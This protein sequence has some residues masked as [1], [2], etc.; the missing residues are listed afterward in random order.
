M[1]GAVLPVFLLVAAVTGDHVSG[2]LQYPGTVVRTQS[3][4]PIVRERKVTKKIPPVH[5]LS[6]S[7]F[8]KARS[9]RLTQISETSEVSLE[10][11]RNFLQNDAIFVPVVHL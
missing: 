6:L 1:F 4:I 11:S 8:S 7:L 5:T 2:I 10:P 3:S 9:T